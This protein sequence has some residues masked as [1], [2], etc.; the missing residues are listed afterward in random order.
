M[1]ERVLTDSEVRYL[2]VSMIHAETERD[3]QQVIGASSL[4]N[5]CDVCLAADLAGVD[6]GV[7]F[8]DRPFLG[9]DLGTLFHAGLNERLPIAQ[10]IY[11]GAESEQAVE[12]CIIDGYGA[13]PGHYDLQPTAWH[14]V[15]WKGSLRKKIALLE[16]YLQS[17]GLHREG[18]EPRWEK[19]KGTKTT[20][21]GYKFKAD[22]ETVVSYS[23]TKYREEM[24]SMAM[25]YLSYYGQQ[26]L[27]MHAKRAR[28]ASLVLIAR[29][30]T[31]YFD[32]PEYAGYDSEDAKHDIFVLSFAYDRAYTEALIQRGNDIWAALE[33]GVMISQFN[34]HPDCYVCK[35]AA[36]KIKEGGPEVEYQDLGSPAIIAPGA[37]EPADQIAHDPAKIAA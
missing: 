14:I 12:C 4:S 11:P 16:D 6:R 19:Q 15:D 17:R 10:Q 2:A 27:Y 23:A 29:D 31:G 33:R 26:N 35:K 7:N 22:A 24:T 13:V 3:R 5:P 30:G 21:G 34:A 18:L 28:R 1:I 20:E 32:N 8:A 9:R 37:S 25:K 36:Q